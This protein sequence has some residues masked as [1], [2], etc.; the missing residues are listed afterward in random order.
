[1]ATK[2]TITITVTLRN[3]QCFEHHPPDEPREYKLKYINVIRQELSKQKSG[4]LTLTYP[5]GIYN[6]DDISSIHFQETETVPE[7]PPIGY[8]I[9]RRID[10]QDDQ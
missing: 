6:M 4:I 7:I 9:D 5:I 1:M 2:E 3:G 10:K 8:R